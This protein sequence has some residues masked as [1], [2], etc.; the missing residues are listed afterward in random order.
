MQEMEEANSE[1]PLS[2]GS[3]SVKKYSLREQIQTEINKNDQELQKKS[4]MEGILY[5][6]SVVK[7]TSVGKEV[8]KMTE[9]DR[10]NVQL[11]FDSVN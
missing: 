9:K 7:E 4:N 3:K 5:L 6:Q 1:K 10:G 11:K 2:M 8:A